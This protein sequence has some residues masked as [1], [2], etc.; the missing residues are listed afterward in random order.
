[1]MLSD[2]WGKALWSSWRDRA[3]TDSQGSSEVPAS[4]TVFQAQ[5]SQS[6]P[7]QG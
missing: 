1:M 6:W 7:A 5:P 2:F 3:V 4:D